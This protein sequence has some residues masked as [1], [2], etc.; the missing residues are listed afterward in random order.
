MNRGKREVTVRPEEIECES[1]RLQVEL[2][3]V[4]REMNAFLSAPLNHLTRASGAHFLRCFRITE[5][6][7]G[8]SRSLHRHRHQ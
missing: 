7:S 2:A 8:L 6:M 5:S 1:L 4:I 3:D